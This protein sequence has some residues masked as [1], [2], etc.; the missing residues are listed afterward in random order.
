[1]SQEATARVGKTTI[2][3]EVKGC[4]NC[5]THFASGWSEAKKVPIIIN[6]RRQ[7]ISIPICDDCRCSAS[8]AALKG[9]RGR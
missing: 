3:F 4:T 9:G 8:P 5:G 2:V 1:M 7:L 6:G